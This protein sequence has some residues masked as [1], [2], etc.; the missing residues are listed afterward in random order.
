MGAGISVMTTGEGTPPDST[1]LSAQIFG[2][3]DP[4]CAGLLPVEDVVAA[5]QDYF[6]QQSTVPPVDWIRAVIAKHDEDRDGALTEPQLAHAIDSL[7][8]C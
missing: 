3:L 6:S 7:R 2:D 5:A 1:L 4:E 8:R